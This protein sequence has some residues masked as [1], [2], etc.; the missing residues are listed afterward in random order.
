MPFRA[1]EEATRSPKGRGRA[2]AFTAAACVLVASVTAARAEV[3]HAAIARAALQ[4]VIRPVSL[5]SPK[6]PTR[7]AARSRRCA[8]SLPLRAS[9]TRKMPSPRRSQNGARSRSCASG[10]SSRIVVMSA[11]SIGPIPKALARVRSRTCSP[12]RIQRSQSWQNSPKKAWRCKACRRSNICSMATAPR[13]LPKAVATVSS[14]A[15]SPLPS[16]PTSRPLP[17]R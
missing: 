11:C 1:I 4:D 5:D 2:F 8:A 10:R 13:R 12:R 17:R 3:D 7:L 9:R 16:R 15:A 14:A 6:A